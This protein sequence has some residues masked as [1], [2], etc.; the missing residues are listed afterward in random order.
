MTLL[1]AFVLGVA[2]T[3]LISATVLLVLVV[4]DHL[5]KRR[6]PVLRQDFVERVADRITERRPAPTPWIYHVLGRN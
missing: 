2:A 6:E 5:R 3:F 4:F 1:Q